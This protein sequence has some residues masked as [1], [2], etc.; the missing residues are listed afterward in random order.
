MRVTHTLA[1]PLMPRM[2]AARSRRVRA[3]PASAV[4]GFSYSGSSSVSVLVN[5]IGCSSSRWRLSPLF[6]HK[7]GYV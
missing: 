5:S 3:S 1:A 4:H 2:V 7:P 6:Y